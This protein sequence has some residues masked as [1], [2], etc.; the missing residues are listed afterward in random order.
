VCRRHPLTGLLAASPDPGLRG[1]AAVL[2]AEVAMAGG[3]LAGARE[4][5]AG[6]L[7]GDGT[8]P[9]VRCQAWEL[10]GRSLRLPDLAAAE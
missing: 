10:I 1:Q 6:A 7:A 8:R 2:A 9:D 4:L 5:A 3:D